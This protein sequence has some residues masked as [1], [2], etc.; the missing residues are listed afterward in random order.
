[1]RISARDKAQLK[2]MKIFVRARTPTALAAIVIRVWSAEGIPLENVPVEVLFPGMGV[3]ASPAIVMI[4]GT[5][6]IV[7]GS[8]AAGRVS[9]HT[10]LILASNAGL[11]AFTL[12]ADDHVYPFVARCGNATY[13]GEIATGQP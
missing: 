9:P 10:E 7:R 13:E 1:M 6:L 2:R 5:L 11:A 3:A 12:A 8:S 4:A